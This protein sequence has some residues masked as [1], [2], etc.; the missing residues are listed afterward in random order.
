MQTF[1]D[2]AK[3]SKNVINEKKKMRFNKNNFKLAYYTFMI[4]QG[5]KELYYSSRVK[6][7]WTINILQTF[8]HIKIY[9]KIYI[10]RTYIY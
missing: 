9:W 1:R 3:G 5:K 2:Q 10:Y 7:Y 4:L 8:F 6:I